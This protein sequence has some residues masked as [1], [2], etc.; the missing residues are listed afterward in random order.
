VKSPPADTQILDVEKALSLKLNH[1]FVD[2]VREHNG[3]I[4]EPNVFFIALN[5]SDDIE[6]GV[7]EFIEL[8]E[9]PLYASMIRDEVGNY[10]IPIA[11]DPCGNYVCISNEKNDGEIYFW[12]HEFPEGKALIKLAPSLASFLAMLHPFDVDEITLEPGQVKSVWVSPE[13]LKK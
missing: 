4:P 8:S 5:G 2:F 10:I 11:H 7:D 1:D 9:I 12:E 3:A 6:T 13:L